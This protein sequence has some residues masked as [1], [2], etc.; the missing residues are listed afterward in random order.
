VLWGAEAI[1]KIFK[2]ANAGDLPIE[3]ATK[4][5]LVVNLKTPKALGLKHGRYTAEAIARPR[6]GHWSLRWVGWKCLL[7]CVSPPIA[8]PPLPRAGQS[9]GDCGNL[10]LTDCY[11]LDQ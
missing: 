6:A 10:A 9:C 3:G 11:S 8:P 2:G 4:F 5:E 7:R 1:G